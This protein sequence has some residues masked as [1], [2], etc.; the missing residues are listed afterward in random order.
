MLN[1]AAFRYRDRRLARTVQRKPADRH[2][3]NDAGHGAF[4]LPQAVA[5]FRRGRHRGR[6]PNKGGTRAGGARI[7]WG[8]PG[9]SFGARSPS[10]PTC[11]CRPHGRRLLT[12]GM[13]W[14]SNDIGQS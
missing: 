13:P 6:M 3:S 2:I 12:S 10:V 4:R 14:Q 8:W 7:G 11:S 1:P 5:A 9:S